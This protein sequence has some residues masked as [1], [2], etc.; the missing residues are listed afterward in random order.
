MAPVYSVPNN[1]PVPIAS[2]E[3]T[4]QN[5]SFVEIKIRLNMYSPT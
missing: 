1:V 2:A 5:A 4:F 3:V